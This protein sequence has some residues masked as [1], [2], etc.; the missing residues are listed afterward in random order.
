MGATSFYSKNISRKLICPES[1]KGVGRMRH[2]RRD[3]RSKVEKWRAVGRVNGELMGKDGCER[4]GLG[5]ASELPKRR[6]GMTGAKT[7]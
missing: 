2:Q 4:G 1:W 5:L 6:P 3:G 7:L